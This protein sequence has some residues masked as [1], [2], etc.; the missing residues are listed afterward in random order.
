MIDA[1]PGMGDQP[2]P[3]PGKTETGYLQWL[4]GTYWGPGW[5]F[6]SLATPDRDLTRKAAGR[7][8]ADVEQLLL[9]HT[10]GRAAQALVDLTSRTII[11]VRLHATSR[12]EP[13]EAP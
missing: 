13:K 11:A 8:P 4:A 12:P 9:V 5:R 6:W 1:L 2:P 7:P 3:R 10:D